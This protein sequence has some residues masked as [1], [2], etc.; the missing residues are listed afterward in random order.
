[1]PRDEV[2]QSKVRGAPPQT[3]GALL[4]SP[5][6]A[7][8]SLP[9]PLGSVLPLPRVPSSAHSSGSWVVMCM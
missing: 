7:L 1:M 6:A 2:A 3:P 8:L 9:L 5:T 4:L